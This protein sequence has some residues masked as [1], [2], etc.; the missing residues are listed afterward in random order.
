MG[1]YAQLVIGPAGSGKSSFCT[2]IYEHCVAERRTVHCVN[3][4]PAAESFAYP[5]SIDIRDLISIDDVAEELKL[6][7][8]GALIFCMEYLLENISWLEEQVGAFNDDY[9]LI[10]C[11]GQVELYTHIPVMRGLV[12]WLGKWQYN[13]CC[14]FLLDAVFVSDASKFA[15]GMLGALSA[16]LQLELPHINVLS[17]VDLLDARQQADLDALC[18]PDL[19]ALESKMQREGRHHGDKHKLLTAEIAQLLGAFNMVSF[20]PYSKHDRASVECIL[21]HID[22]A[23]QFGEDEEPVDPEKWNRGKDEQQE[24][25]HERHAAMLQQKVETEQ[26]MKEHMGADMDMVDI[27]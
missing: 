22:H 27:D 3:L 5:V 10:D 14:A 4:D 16:M 20:L 26:K 7:P 6:G 11:P 1:K 17:K 25:M 13:M 9:L 23:V 12:R 19:A 24:R 18:D 8:N 2:A 21:G 15:S